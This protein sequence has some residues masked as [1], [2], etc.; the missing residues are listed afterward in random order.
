MKW[1]NNAQGSDGPSADHETNRVPKSRLRR[2][3]TIT[4][5]PRLESA[6]TVCGV[7]GTSDQITGR[8]GSSVKVFTCR[9][10][11][12]TT[13]VNDGRGYAFAVWN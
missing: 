9:C 11:K 7:C 1:R 5:T 10:C 3:T 6:T 2:T 8:P 4:K 13:S 12:T